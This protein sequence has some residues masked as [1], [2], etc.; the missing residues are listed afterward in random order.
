M[1]LCGIYLSNGTFWTVYLKET[2]HAFLISVC[3]RS[4]VRISKMAKV[5][6]NEV[7]T[8]ASNSCWEKLRLQIIC[9]TSIKA[10]GHLRH[11]GL[12]ERAGIPHV[13]CSSLLFVKDSQSEEKLDELH[14][15]KRGKDLF[16]L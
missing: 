4:T 5:S 1:I 7:C 13:C 9:L 6:N 15:Y 11:T 3:H 14:Q 8:C 12:A 10:F 2:F 16:E